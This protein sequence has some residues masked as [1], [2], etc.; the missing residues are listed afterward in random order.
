MRTRSWFVD[1]SVNTTTND[2][3]DPIWIWL[4]SLAGLTVV[5]GPIN[6]RAV[7]M[8]HIET[9]HPEETLGPK[10]GQPSELE[11]RN[12]TRVGCFRKVSVSCLHRLII[13]N[14]H[15]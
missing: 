2:G 8:T 12:G 5:Y 9:E 6:P 4:E 13:S 10:L 14:F 3:L 7:N 15:L 11:A 1:Q